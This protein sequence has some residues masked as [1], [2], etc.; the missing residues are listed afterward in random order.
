M[1]ATAMKLFFCLYTIGIIGSFPALWAKKPNILFIMAAD[2]GWLD[3]ACQGNPLVETPTLARL[4][5]VFTNYDKDGSGRIAMAES[6]EWSL[7]DAL[8]R[9]HETV[10]RE[11]RQ[12]Q[13]KLERLEGVFDGDV[14]SP[15]RA[16]S[17]REKR[18][19]EGDNT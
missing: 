11:N 17:R 4:A 6:R 3:L 7:R 19:S 18:V 13:A 9:S 1:R 5:K 16:P 10:L 15:A 8:R 14:T 2:L 12:L